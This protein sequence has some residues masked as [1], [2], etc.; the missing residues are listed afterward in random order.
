MVMFWFG[1]VAAPL[2]GIISI[3]DHTLAKFS[4]FNDCLSIVWRV[5]FKC[6]YWAMRK[7]YFT[8]SAHDS[9]PVVRILV[10]D[11]RHLWNINILRILPVSK[12]FCIIWFMNNNNNNNLPANGVQR[13]VLYHL[14]Q[15]NK[16][17]KNEALVNRRSDECKC[18]KIV[19]VDKKEKKTYIMRLYV[20]IVSST[21][22]VENAK[23]LSSPSSLSLWL[24]SE[25][26]SSE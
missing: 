23:V 26:R 12:Y 11:F 2:I 14:E 24:P 13:N 19:S 20:A 8:A 6:S 25:L 5:S 7:G 3:T 21:S 18:V 9:F 17:T 15:K 4:N 22:V 1:C 10:A 16:A